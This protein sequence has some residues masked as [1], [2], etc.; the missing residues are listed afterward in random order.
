[1]NITIGKYY[2]LS[3][4][5]MQEFRGKKP[6][7]NLVRVVSRMGDNVSFSDSTGSNF[8]V[9]MKQFLDNAKDP[10]L[11]VKP[12]VLQT[13]IKP[14]Q[15]QVVIP[16]PKPITPTPV[17]PAP[18]PTPVTPVPTPV[19]PTPQPAPVTPQPTPVTPTPTPQPTPP[20]QDNT[21]VVPETPVSPT[22]T[23]TQPPVNPYGD[24]GDYL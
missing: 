13:T 1:M 5:L 3:N 17:T 10:R 8:M 18:Q 22:P 21:V 7:N 24:G 2:L 23:P 12:R 15:A 14:P 19:T 9:T 11:E 16:T 6:A 20:K 4:D